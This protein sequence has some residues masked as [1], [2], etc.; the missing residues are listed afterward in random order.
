ML[1]SA[2]I[3]AYRGKAYLPTEAKL[4]S[5]SYIPVD[6]V[7]VTTLT[8]EGLTTAITHLSTV[9]HPAGPQPLTREFWKTYTEP[10]QKATRA[11]SQK[12]LVVE[13]LHYT[14]LWTP[15]QILVSMPKP[16]PFDRVRDEHGVPRVFPANTPLHDVLTS[17]LDHMQQLAQP[18]P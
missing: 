10:L 12:Q 15:D 6:P 3:L 11:R 5:G 17:I 16:N 9:G 18:T 4:G 7:L 13:G 1:E 2:S 14:I 8:L